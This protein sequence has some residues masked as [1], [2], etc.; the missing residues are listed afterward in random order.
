MWGKMQ[1]E[2][3]VSYKELRYAVRIPEDGLRESRLQ[4]RLDFKN[5][6]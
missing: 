1:G 2:F 3:G 5:T 6:I 4:I